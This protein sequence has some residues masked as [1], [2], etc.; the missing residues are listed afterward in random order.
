MVKDVGPLNLD[1]NL[2]TGQLLFTLV[3]GFPFPTKQGI[4]GYE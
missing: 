4:R 1:L 2:G 3:L